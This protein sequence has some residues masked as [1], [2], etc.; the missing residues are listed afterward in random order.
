MQHHTEREGNQPESKDA[1]PSIIDSGGASRPPVPP[2]SLQPLFHPDSVAIIGASTNPHKPSGQPLWA[3]IKNRFPGR[4]FPVNPSHTEVYGVTCHPDVASL[5]QA[6]DLAIIAL[7]AAAALPALEACISR[8]VRGVIVFSSGFAEASEEGA[9]LQAQLAARAREAGIPL[10][11]PNCMGIISAPAKLGANFLILR[12]QPED[13]P[14]PQFASIVTQSGSVG[15]AFFE[16]AQARGIGTTRMISSGNEAVLECAD[17]LAYL[18]QDPHTACITGYVEGVAD[19]ERF[20]NA[21]AKTVDAKKPV[22]LLRGGR[23]AQGIRAMQRHTATAPVAQDEAHTTQRIL[24]KY[25]VITVPGVEAM[26]SLTSCFALGKSAGMRAAV[27]TPFGG[28]GIIAADAFADVGIELPLLAQATQERIAP[29]VPPFASTE[30]PVDVTPAAMANVQGIR[31]MAAAILEDPQVDMLLLCLW[32]WPEA[33]EAQID[34][35]AAIVQE[36]TLLVMV[37]VWGE[38]P[39]AQAVVNAL[40]KQGVPAER[41]IQTAAATM[42]RYANWQ[43]A[44]AAPSRTLSSQGTTD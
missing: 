38:E 18:A 41:D 33:M 8:G 17:Y 39:T 14:F 35:L 9:A 1:V 15:A 7:P 26:A 22:I 40:R 34:M 23:S 16:A 4:V 5:P 29:H 30:N 6:P 11:G 27:L 20:R 31:D 36:S 28:G 25:H 42:A 37:L 12:R 32:V 3:C 21:L 24:S 43:Q 19:V 2:A 44:T 13:L 10:C